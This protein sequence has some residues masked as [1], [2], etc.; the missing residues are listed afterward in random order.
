MLLANL[1]M[2]EI[3]EVS[4]YW[5]MFKQFENYCN[6]ELHFKNQFMKKLAI[7]LMS[8]TAVLLT[9]CGD[10]SGEK[11]T[12]PTDTITATTTTPNNDTMVVQQKD[13]VPEGT[14]A[15]DP[16]CNMDYEAKWTLNSKHEAT[17]V[18]FCSEL[19]K[20]T[21]DKNPAKYMTAAAGTDAHAN[22]NH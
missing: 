9:S 22:H 15:K 13:A 12:T 6:F 18:F 21:F 10:G 3:I 5:N 16:V 14:L 2:V 7:L 19:C 4:L 11:A 17:T 20:E 8:A 1:L